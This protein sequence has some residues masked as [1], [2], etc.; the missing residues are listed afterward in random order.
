MRLK[1]Y[2]TEESSIDVLYKECSSYIQE[3]KS[4]GLKNGLLRGVKDSFSIKKIDATKYR[5]PRDIALSNSAFVDKIYKDTVGINLRSSTGFCTHMEKMAKYYGNMYY[6]VPIGSYKL[7]V[8]PKIRDLFTDIFAWQDKPL[9]SGTG[10]PLDPMKIVSET[11]GDDGIRIPSDMQATRIKSTSTRV[12]LPFLLTKSEKD[13]INRLNQEYLSQD[14]LIYEKLFGIFGKKQKQESTD[15]SRKLSGEE[16]YNLFWK[17]AFNNLETKVID[18]IKKTR[19]MSLS[20]TL[21]FKE[22]EIMLSCK[23]YYLV[24]PDLLTE[25]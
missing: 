25:L 17:Y 4:V 13:R 23:E 7:Y 5:L 14:N 18:L 16:A 11:I 19:Q 3:W 8:N 22:H 2:L 21:N 9:F 15:G 20:E 12:L 1:K 6:A 10:A 24:S